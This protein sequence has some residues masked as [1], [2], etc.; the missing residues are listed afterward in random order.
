MNA[1]SFIEYNSTEVT[2][3]YSNLRNQTKFRLNEINTL[4]DYFNSQIQERN[5]MGKKLSKY[6]VVFNYFG[7]TWIVLST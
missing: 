6:I 4:K 1:C 7:K 5:I 2:N 3:T